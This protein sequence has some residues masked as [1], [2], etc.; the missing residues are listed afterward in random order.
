MPVT[1]RTEL[2]EQT[3]RDLLEGLG[4][5]EP[6]LDVTVESL[7][8]GVA[9]TVLAASWRGGDVVV[10]QAL[11]KLRVEADWPF[12]PERTNIERECLTYLAGVLPTGSVPEVVAF[13]AANHLLVISRAPRDGIV[14]KEL[15]LAG[16]V[17]SA[18]GADVGRLLGELHRASSQDAAA[19]ATFAAKWPLIQGRTDPFH[20]TVAEKHQDMREAILAEVERLEGTNSALVLGDFSPKNIIV[21]SDRGPVLID[22]EVAHYGDPAFDVAYL[23]THLALKARHRPTSAPAI[24]ECAAAFL[25]AYGESAEDARPPD[26][27]VVAELGCLLLSRVDGKSPAEY[28]DAA[29]DGETVRRVARVLLLEPPGAAL[30]ALGY[31]VDEFAPPVG[32]P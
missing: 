11:P 16:D 5:M 3:V 4:V 12:D 17:D 15:L 18:I 23:L 9:N 6:G 19:A 14:W 32:R 30:E 20:R 1:A 2:N 8:G 10:K 13:D 22:F 24:R 29:A 26:A 27:A 7:S 28:L 31:A 21:Y 25:R